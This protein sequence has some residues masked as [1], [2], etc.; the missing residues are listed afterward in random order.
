MRLPWNNKIS[1]ATDTCPT[2]NENISVFI[3]VL[4]NSPGKKGKA[5]GSRTKQD[6]L[7]ST[8]LETLDFHSTNNIFSDNTLYISLVLPILRSV[9]DNAI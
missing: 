5:F 6:G 2:I 1:I 3:L 4:V 9:P 7:L 8:L